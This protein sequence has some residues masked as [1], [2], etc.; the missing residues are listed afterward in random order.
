MENNRDD[1]TQNKNQQNSSGMQSGAG[2]ER[3]A[4]EN[5]QEGSQWDNYQTRSLSSE[6]GEKLEESDLLQ[7]DEAKQQN[8]GNAS[9]GQA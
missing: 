4:D 5:P 6:G 7:A 8:T 9:G 1:Q 3:G 2:N